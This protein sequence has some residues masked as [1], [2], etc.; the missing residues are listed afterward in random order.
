M[1]RTRFISKRVFGFMSDELRNELLK[2]LDESEIVGSYVAN[3][4]T[5]LDALGE[6]EL[7]RILVNKD[8]DSL[9][10]QRFGE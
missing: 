1:H 9:A 6:H 7:A 8:S 2:H 3:V 4:E 10:L 5:K